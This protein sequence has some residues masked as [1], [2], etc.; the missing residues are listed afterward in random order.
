MEMPDMLAD[1]MLEKHLWHLLS[2]WPLQH[3]ASH[4]ANNN[5]NHTGKCNLEETGD[6]NP[7]ANSSAHIVLCN[8]ENG[9]K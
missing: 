1:P 9:Q 8:Q 5:A 4:V 7:F 2:L 6:V 3:F